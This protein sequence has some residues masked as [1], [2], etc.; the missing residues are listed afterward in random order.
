MY[1]SLVVECLASVL[2]LKAKFNDSEFL[3]YLLERAAILVK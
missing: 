1:I 2:D 3:R